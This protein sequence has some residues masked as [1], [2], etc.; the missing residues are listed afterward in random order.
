MKITES[1]L[2]QMIRGVIREFTGTAGAAGAKPAGYKSADTKSKESTYDTKK[3][4]YDTKKT[5]WDTKKASL[6][7]FDTSQKYRKS[8]GKGG[9]Y[10]YS[11][12]GGRG[13]SVNPA[14]S[15]VANPEAVSRRQK[16]DAEKAKDSAKTTRDT[17]REA[18]LQKTV[19]TQKPPS[20][21]G[22]GYGTGKS[23]G[24]GKGKGKKKKD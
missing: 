15:A 1:K 22:A 11:A 2:R 8:G 16:D 21:G 9:G 19:P 20:G 24:K 17:A 14:Y 10:Q 18:D 7:S 12:T 4:D 23:A 5:D 13:W 3:S 6:D